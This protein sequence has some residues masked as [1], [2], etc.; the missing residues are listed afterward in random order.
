LAINRYAEFAV[1]PQNL[2]S[3]KLDFEQF[4]HLLKELEANSA[5]A[6]PNGTRIL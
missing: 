5:Q 2:L 4:R 3:G 1:D 6:F